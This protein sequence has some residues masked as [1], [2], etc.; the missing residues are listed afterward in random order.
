MS[1]ADGPRRRCLD[2]C[3]CN[4]R[5]CFVAQAIQGAAPPVILPS[6]SLRNSRRRWRCAIT[7]EPPTKI[8]P[9]SVDQV[10]KRHYRHGI[11]NGRAKLAKGTKNVL[12]LCRVAT[13]TRRRQN[14]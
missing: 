2:D 8:R 5:C 4:L 13:P 9:W 14:C 6:A 10:T 11:G 7:E 3:G 12:P 1:N